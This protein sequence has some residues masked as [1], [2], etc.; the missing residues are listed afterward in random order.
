MRRAQ[1]RRFRIKAKTPTRLPLLDLASH[2]F[3]IQ[4]QESPK[5]VR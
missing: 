2:R 4:H 5:P 1:A 3:K